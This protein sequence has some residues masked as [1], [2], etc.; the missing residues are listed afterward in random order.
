MHEAY[1]L[2]QLLFYVSHL[3]AK[4][5]Q[6]AV[7]VQDQIQKL[8]VVSMPKI[9]AKHK[10]N[11]TKSQTTKQNKTNPTTDQKTP[12]AVDFFSVRRLLASARSFNTFDS[13]LQRQVN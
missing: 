9:K 11:K 3:S 4:M 1:S 10:Q 6:I 5:A 13:M 12:S 2:K 7:P 8:V